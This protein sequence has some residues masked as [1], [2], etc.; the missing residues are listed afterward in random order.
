MRKPS[1][2][3]NHP[4]PFEPRPL[5]GVCKYVVDGD[6]LDAFIDEGLYDYAYI[7]IRIKDFDAPETRTTNLIE[8]EHGLQARAFA[9]ILLLG[10][11]VKLLTFKDS[12]TFG[13]FVADVFFWNDAGELV[14]FADTMR[15]AGYEK[16]ASYP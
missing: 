1:D 8:K 7:T 5:R 2:F 4:M 9:S 10:K 14:S 13:R 3:D 6:T 11:P 15:A 16:R 12:E